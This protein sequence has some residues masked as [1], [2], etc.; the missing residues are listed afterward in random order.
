MQ[1]TDL[2]KTPEPL[3]LESMDPMK[4]WVLGLAVEPDGTLAGPGHRKFSFLEE[5]ACPDDCNRDHENE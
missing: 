1:A 3:G 2:T 4:L 5:C